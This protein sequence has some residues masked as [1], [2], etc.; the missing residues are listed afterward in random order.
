MSESNWLRLQALVCSPLLLMS[1]L[2]NFC[3]LSDAEIGTILVD[4]AI[5][6]GMNDNQLLI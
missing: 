1:L 2:S 4:K 5:F 3:F 6:Q